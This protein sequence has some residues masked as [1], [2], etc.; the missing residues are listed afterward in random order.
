M[1]WSRIKFSIFI[2][3]DSIILKTQKIPDET[4]FELIPPTPDVPLLPDDPT[5]PLLLLPKCCV[6]KEL[7]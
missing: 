5:R 7:G 6:V 4:E 1:N 3:A 2:R